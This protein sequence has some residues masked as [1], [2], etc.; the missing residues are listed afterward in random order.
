MARRQL[1]QTFV[2]PK[3][4]IRVLGDFQV[5]KG[6]APQE[7]PQSRKTRALLAYLI[8]SGR[9]HRR[10]RLCNLLWDVPDDPRGSLRWSLSRLRSVVDEPGYQRIV[11]DREHVF[12]DPNGATIDLFEARRE[13]A[14]G[15][16]ALSTQRLLDLA[17]QFRGELL[18]D[19]TLTDPHEFELWLLT[20]KE[21]A[22]R[23]R[24]SLLQALV[25][26]LDAEGRE[27]AAGHARDWVA[28]DP[29][30]VSAHAMLIHVLSVAGRREEAERQQEISMQ[31][32]RSAG[33]SGLEVLSEALSRGSPSRAV[34]PE[35]EPD[36]R[37][38]QEIRFCTTSDGVRIAHATV[39]D[40][41]PLI[42]TANWLNHLEYDWDS[43]IW[44]HVFRGLAR[45]HRLI[46]Y[47][48]RG[49]GLSDWD[50]EE[51][52]F[53]AYVNDLEAVVEAAGVERFPLL[54]ISQGCAISIEYAVRN[55]GRVTR[56]VLHGG[57]AA[58]WRVSEDPAEI[59][60]REAMQTLILH[61]WGQN[62]PAFR[63]VFTSSFIP[64]GTPE[65]FRWMNELMR[66]STSP[67][68]AIRLQEAL[69]R[70]DVRDRLPM[71]RVPTLVLHSRNDSR[72]PYRG[73]LEL[74]QGIPNARFITL[75]S[76]NHLI[77][78][79]EPEFPRFM[80]AIRAFL[81]GE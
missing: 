67:Q 45:D 68:N 1:E 38:D 30:S 11:A 78:E 52:S 69:S 20:E 76:N 36:I 24:A 28:A 79:H 25:H 55:P 54:G 61:G 6:G 47:D 56:L 4:A 43:P 73:G 41:P 50:V 13:L 72:V 75:E 32:L 58:G 18:E 29:Y 44:R 77:L 33:A 7:F 10:E 57:Y 63:Q 59:A 70:V 51:I 8:L 22:R 5:L 34:V 9:R 21:T 48:A 46:R 27:E 64:E 2:S 3:L 16:N 65:Q 39:G 14:G 15:A 81:S 71:L 62:N 35:R 31:E 37:L 49:N 19:L 74:A 26:R 12:F 53:D 23:T 80:T 40:G 42:K 60:R 17:G 66:V